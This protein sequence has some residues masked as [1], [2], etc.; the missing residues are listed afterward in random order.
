M[1]NRKDISTLARL[2]CNE[3]DSQHA[4]KRTKPTR[5]ACRQLR[6]DDVNG[7]IEPANDRVKMLL[8][9][10]CTCTREEKKMRALAHTLTNIPNNHQQVYVE[11]D[12]ALGILKAISPVFE[13]SNNHSPYAGA[14]PFLMFS[15][16]SQNI[17]STNQR[18]K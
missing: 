12:M 5:P 17:T 2:G 14:L 6:K 16:K 13:H 18:E 10:A 9:I 1:Q 11:H 8:F 7:E 4:L 15:G 3:N